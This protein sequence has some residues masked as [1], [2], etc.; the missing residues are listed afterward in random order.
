MIHRLVMGAEKE[1]V[2]MVNL[3]SNIKIPKRMK[4]KL[5]I[6]LSFIGFISIDNTIKA[7]NVPAAVT[8][9]S[10]GSGTITYPTNFSSSTKFNYV[11]TYRPLEPMASIP[12]FNQT[13]TMKLVVSTDYEDGWGR[14]LA[15][16]LR[17]G[18]SKDVIKP[19]DNRVRKLTADYLPYA[20]TFHSKFH[21]G[22]FGRQKSFYSS[23]FSNES[24]SAYTKNVASYI[25]GVA[26]SKTYVP[27][28]ATVTNSIGTTTT[29]KLN[30][31]PSNDTIFKIT[32]SGGNICKNG[33]YL[34]NQLRITE[35]KTDTV[36]NIF[37]KEY[38][39]KNDR[40]ICKKVGNSSAFLVT[41]YVYDELGRLVYMI[42]PKASSFLYSSTCISNADLTC[43]AYIYDMHGR[44]IK[45]HTPGKVGDDYM[46]Y[47]NDHRLAMSQSPLLRSEGKW[48]FS[49]YDVN[50]R[51]ILTGLYT[52]TDSFDY[53]RGIISGSAAMPLSKY[54]QNN[55]LVDMGITLEHYFRYGI[56]NNTYPDTI[57]NCEILTYNYYDNYDEI[58]ANSVTFDSLDKALYSTSS[59]ADKPMPY[60]MVHGRLTANRVRIMDNGF[61]NNFIN[62]WI[63]N[64]FFYDEKG[65]LIQ[66]QTNTPWTH[67]WDIATTQYTF[68]G[69]PI[70]EIVR[71]Y[72]WPQMQSQPHELKMITRY[73]YE[74][75]TGR[76]AGVEQKID[77]S[78]WHP[79]S[80][81]VYDDLGRV[82]TKKLGGK[83]EIQNYSYNI[84]GQLVGI[85]AD[86]LFDTT[87]TQV[88]GNDSMSFWEELNYENGFTSPRYDNRLSGFKWR[89]KGSKP[90]AYGYV[91]DGFGRMTAA[92]FKECNYANNWV[93]TIT[94]FS[95][96]GIA[97]DP[98]GNLVSMKQRGYDMSMKPADIDILD[99]YYDY[100]NRLLQVTD[101]TSLHSPINDFVDGNIG[102]NDY[103]YDDN[104]NLTVDNNKGITNISYNFRDQPIEITTNNGTVKNIYDAGGQL[105]Q[106]IIQD[107]TLGTSTYRYW[108]PIVF[109][110]DS[111]QYVR[112][113]EGRARWVDTGYYK[114]DYFVKDHQGNVRTV[115]ASDV[116]FDTIGYHAGF[117]LIARAVE[118]QTFDR[119]GE[120]VDMSPTVTPY[121]LSSGWLNG[122]AAE[123]QIGAA[124]LL[125]AMAGD[126]FNLNGYGYYEDTTTAN[127]NTYATAE[128]M[129]SS[130]L[131]AMSGGIVQT[132]GSEGGADD[133][134]QTINNL[135]STS[136]YD[137]YDKLRQ[138][139][140]DP[141]YPHCYL[142]YIVF[143]EDMT[144]SKSNSEV[145]QL[146]GAANDWIHL[147][148]DQVKTMP[149][150]G[151]LLTYF[152][153]QSAV[154]V[155]IDNIYAVHYKGRLL[156][157]QH[158]YPYGL[159]I[160]AGTQANL[161]L[162]NKYLTQGNRMQDELG[163]NLLDF[164]A[165][166]YDQ[167]IGRFT[168]VD[169][170][171]D[172]G[173]EF[174]SPYHFSGNDPANFT[175]PLG[176]SWLARF[177]DGFFGGT[178]ACVTCTAERIHTD[179]NES[180][181]GTTQLVMAQMSGGG[182][183][184][185][186]NGGGGTSSGGGGS[187]EVYKRGISNPRFINPIIGRLKTTAERK[188]ENAV[189]FNY[190]AKFMAMAIV[191]IKVNLEIADMLLAGDTRINL[192]AGEILSDNTYASHKEIPGRE[193]NLMPTADHIYSIIN[194]TD[195]M[196][197][198]GGRGGYSITGLTQGFGSHE[199]FGVFVDNYAAAVDMAHGA[200]DQ[201]NPNHG[202]SVDTSNGFG[203]SWYQFNKDAGNDLGAYDGGF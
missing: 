171:A 147:Q 3:N 158:Y 61:S 83:A 154:P 62:Q 100:G 47:D 44:L 174:F 112:N 5:T 187:V 70:R 193:E 12:Y 108:G 21:N 118:D 125:H 38:Y 25:N 50:G 26:T 159:P 165:R 189:T 87:F 22:V 124:L 11:R 144:I 168:A 33:V 13:K 146:R 107:N 41:Y 28:K 203:K 56:Y 4:T 115:I 53:W 164:N 170:L 137:V 145:I 161:S 51:E 155:A 128:D 67:E 142:N 85:N 97:F 116:T 199:A 117:E 77:T 133:P 173:Q 20:D 19:Y 103:A 54:D 31:Y 111:L 169:L 46:V 160:E 89:A 138:D 195:F 57:Y 36:A 121:D 93:D 15:T 120:I 30:E 156:E 68:T 182:G 178:L 90:M 40:L 39:D 134:Q 162:A 91:Y 179:G 200:N 14:P 98:N 82:K 198:Y 71:H 23:L 18:S 92:D 150:N 132:G 24:T 190:T 79:V 126:Q 74:A 75:K 8:N 192:N 80:T 106:K 135:L 149:I 148:F 102:T 2:A 35:T 42:P 73:A 180:L 110:E 176:L 184:N 167:Q 95:V 202:K 99:Y 114:Y 197:L 191:Q 140:T 65:R 58:P 172:G 185:G 69:Q 163:I 119:I 7:Q 141:A 84:R 94:D 113:R 129:L 63:E 131:G 109:K 81:F 175:D 55:N 52:G 59:I 194:I 101:D 78:A 16:V 86:K 127:L 17:N 48:Q 151:Y 88:T 143:N 105:L 37:T 1:E 45:K 139:A 177:L 181:G 6:I 43:F 60:L 64:V 152:S 34:A 27:G 186:G 201:F 104:G 153:N 196:T 136:N 123:T 166:N 96:S 10:P 130:L 49:L 76:L 9:T 66:T 29:V 72:N 157:E 188:I 122:S 183:G 32:Y